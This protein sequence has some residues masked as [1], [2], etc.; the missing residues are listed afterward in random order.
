MSTII[1]VLRETEMV[2]LPDGRTMLAADAERA[3]R[4]EEALL[5]ERREREARGF[6][7]ASGFSG[8]RSFGSGG[9]DSSGLANT[10]ISNS[11]SNH[12]DVRVVGR[13]RPG[14]V[15]PIQTAKSKIVPEPDQIQSKPTRSDRPELG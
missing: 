8:G 3:D 9:G 4:L 11:F 5:R 7:G 1:S 10:P 13:A 14:S 2:R 15:K 6:S 12:P